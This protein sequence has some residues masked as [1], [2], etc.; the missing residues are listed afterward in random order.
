MYDPYLCIQL[1]DAVRLWT[2]RFIINSIYHFC[3]FKASMQEACITD[4]GHIRIV[5]ANN[6]IQEVLFP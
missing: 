3:F 6:F 1:D 5:M 2:K 4:Q